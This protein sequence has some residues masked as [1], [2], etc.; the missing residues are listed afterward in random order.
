MDAILPEMGHRV[1]QSLH[2][3]YMWKIGDFSKTPKVS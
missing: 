3:R 2:G 1:R